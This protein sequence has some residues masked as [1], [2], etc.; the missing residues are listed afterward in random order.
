MSTQKI[1]K[2]AKRKNSF[3]IPGSKYLDAVEKYICNV[4]TGVESTLWTPWHECVLPENS[5]KGKCPMDG[6]PEFVS[7][8]SRIQFRG[9]DEREREAPRHHRS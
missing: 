5:T 1:D 9:D 8:F 7:G 2:I 3:I 6:F 4:K